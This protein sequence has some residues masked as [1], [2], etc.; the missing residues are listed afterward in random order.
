MV[1][2]TPDEFKHSPFGGFDLREALSGAAYN[3][4]MSAENFIE[5]VTEHLL[6]WVDVKTFRNFHWTNLTPHQLEYLKKA[7][8]AQTTYTF[9]EGA[10]AFGQFSGADDEKGKVFDP[11]Y[12]DSIEVSKLCIELLIRGGLFNTNIKNRRRTWPNG[13]NY[14]FF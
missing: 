13:S 8:I 9:R 4:S 10:K 1:Y 7:I 5:L 6:A 11:S 3:Q 12:L 2:V 14:G